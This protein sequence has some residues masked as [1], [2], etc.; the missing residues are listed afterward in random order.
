MGVEETLKRL[1][2][3]DGSKDLP[4]GRA[5]DFR[6][7]IFFSFSQGTRISASQTPHAPGDDSLKLGQ[8]SREILADVLQVILCCLVTTWLEHT[9][10]CAV[11]VGRR[12][13]HKLLR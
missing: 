4:G 13:S 10:F 12:L 8:E 3:V 1:V 7:P 2:L 6:R 11:S 9:H 5:I